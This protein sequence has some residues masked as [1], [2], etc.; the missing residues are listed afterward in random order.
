MYCLKNAEAIQAV[1]LID[2]AF[3]YGDGCFSTARIRDSQIELLDRH[4]SRLEDSC[5]RLYLNVN[6][7]LIQKSLQQLEQQ[8]GFLNGTLKIIISR[9][10]GQR[11]YSLPSHAADLWLMYYPQAI[12]DFY[13]DIIHCGLAQRRIGINMP[14]LVGIKSLNRLEQVLLKQEIDQYGWTEA[15]VADVQAQIVEGVS[16][17]CFIRI[18]GQWITPELG[19]NGVHGVMRAELL[20]RMQRQGM[21]CQ[22]RTVHI[23]E[24]PKIESLFFCNALH[25]MRIVAQ[26]DQQILQTQPCVDLFHFLQLH[27]IH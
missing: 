4:L 5:Q 24:V 18:N 10:E 17:N 12:D 22:Q 21:T 3:H 11:G 23:E 25:P 8:Y 15:L 2:R 9:G 13:Y 27:Q 6:L 16:S 1:S 19:Y 20:Q 26:L 14:E 7:Q